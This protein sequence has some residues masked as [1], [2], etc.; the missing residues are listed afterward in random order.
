MNCTLLKLSGYW[1]AGLVRRR[2]LTA[3]LLWIFIHKM[4]SAQRNFLFVNLPTAHSVHAVEVTITHLHS[5]PLTCRII[6]I[7]Q[8][9]YS[10]DLYA[11][12]CFK[13]Q[14]VPQHVGHMGGQVNFGSL[15]QQPQ[16][17]QEF[18]SVD[19]SRHWASSDTPL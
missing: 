19:S 15:W 13:A 1:K 14:A 5:S 16:Y 12:D 9:L 8:G 7:S 11:S 2:A 3:Q 4:N 18:Q 17:I 6:T 10:S